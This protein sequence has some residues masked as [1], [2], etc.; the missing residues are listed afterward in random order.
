MPKNGIPSVLTGALQFGIK[1]GLERI[2][3]LLDLLGNLDIVH[4][5]VGGAFGVDV[6]AN[7]FG[8]ADGIGDLYQSLV[9]DACSHEVLGDMACCVGC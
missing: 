2:T 4:L 9:A 5:D 8:D 7:G 3:K 6:E 1:P